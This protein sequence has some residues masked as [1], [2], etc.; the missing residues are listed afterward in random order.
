MSI[1]QNILTEKLCD[2]GFFTGIAEK[3]SGIGHPANGEKPARHQRG[4][5]DQAAVDARLSEQSGHIFG[6]DAAAAQDALRVFRCGGFSGADG[7]NKHSIVAG[8]TEVGIEAVS[9]CLQSK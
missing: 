5:A 6:L 8:L 9:A 4:A 7:P 2:Q 1:R 3:S